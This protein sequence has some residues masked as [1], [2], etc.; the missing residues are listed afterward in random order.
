[1]PEIMAMGVA[2]IKGQGVA[3]TNTAKNLTLS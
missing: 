2:K 1:M 3:T